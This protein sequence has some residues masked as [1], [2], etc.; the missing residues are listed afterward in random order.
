MY[1]DEIPGHC[2]LALIQFDEFPDRDGDSRRALG[3]ER[4]RWRRS[5]VRKRSEAKRIGTCCAMTARKSGLVHQT[6]ADCELQVADRD[7]LWWKQ[8]CD[9]WASSR[10]KGARLDTQ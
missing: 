2:Y 5:P 10:K 9:E 3:A 4:N 1:F 8:K 6:Q 7:E